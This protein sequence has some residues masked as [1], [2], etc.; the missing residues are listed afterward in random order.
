[1]QSFIQPLDKYL[2][3]ATVALEANPKIRTYLEQAQSAT[4]LD[5][6]TI[7][8]SVGAVLLVSIYLIAGGRAISYVLAFVVPCYHSVKAILSAEKTD[9]QFWL[10]YWVVYSFIITVESIFDFFLSGIP[11]YELMK[12]LLFVSLWHENIQLAGTIFRMF[13]PSIQKALGVTEVQ[14]KSD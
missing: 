4:S 13:T 14:K 12:C 1:M 5:S 2:T 8:G 7:V 3:Q 11:F 10:T 6:Y 9:D